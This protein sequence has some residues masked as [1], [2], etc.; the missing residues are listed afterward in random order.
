MT[1][2]LWLKDRPQK[3]WNV[4]SFIADE[5]RGLWWLGLPR[6]QAGGLVLGGSSI[7][8]RYAVW[9]VKWTIPVENCSAQVQ[10]HAFHNVTDMQHSVVFDMLI[11]SRMHCRMAQLICFWWQFGHKLPHVTYA[12]NQESPWNQITVAVQRELS[13]SLP[14]LTWSFKC[15]FETL[16]KAGLSTLLLCAPW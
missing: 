15:G 1:I 9:Q 11:M 3:G 6:P 8:P 16:L 5:G 12:Q 7:T 13:G 2:C 4:T 14:I 10:Q